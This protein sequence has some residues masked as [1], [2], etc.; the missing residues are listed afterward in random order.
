MPPLL[1]EERETEDEVKKLNKIT[2]VEVPIAIGND[3]RDDDSSMEAGN[4]K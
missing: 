2:E 4:I 1:P 3:A